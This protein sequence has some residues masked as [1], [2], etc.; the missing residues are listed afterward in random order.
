MRKDLKQYLDRLYTEFCRKHSSEDPVWFLHSFDD[1]KDIE[2]AGL[3]TSCYS[4]G[5]V[6]L[7]NDFMMK[8]LK[9]INFKVY[10]FTCNY[11][12][13]KDKK[14]LKGLNYRFNTEK[15]L[16]IL[17]ENLK[18]T[19]DIYGSLER[20]FAIN[21]SDSDENI[22]PALSA[23][24]AEL[25]IKQSGD[26]YYR[27]LI[28]LPES[29]S[30][31]KRINLYLRWMVRKDNIDLGIWKSVSPSKLIMPVDVHVYRVARKLKLVK[32]KSPDLKFAVELTEKLKTFD[33]YDPV[34]YDFALCH[35]DFR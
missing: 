28:P 7:I 31:C 23:F 26:T 1:E 6:Q 18:R 33:P 9:K 16:S 34:K 22:I 5:K 32:R 19:L 13:L 24:T 10:E 8:F 25:N 30:A 29:G 27:Y 15:D 2:I 12:E 35:S 17:L 14:Y 4:Y 3:V 21:Y 11:S 20:L